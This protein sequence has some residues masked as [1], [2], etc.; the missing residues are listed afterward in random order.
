[1]AEIG[2]SHY[3]IITLRV[4]RTR[5]RGLRR[6]NLNGFL[7]ERFGFFLEKKQWRVAKM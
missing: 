7:K 1:M 6:R 3:N 4:G 5:P 2:K